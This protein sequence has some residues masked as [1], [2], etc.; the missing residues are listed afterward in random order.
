MK[1][2]WY[3]FH[4]LENSQDLKLTLKFDWL[5]FSEFRSLVPTWRIKKR[6]EQKTATVCSCQQTNLSQIM[7]ASNSTMQILIADQKS[8]G[9]MIH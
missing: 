8:N 3:L 6:G 5:F 7:I 4:A 1:R 9:Q 2:G